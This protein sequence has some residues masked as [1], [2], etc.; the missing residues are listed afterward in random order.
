[1]QKIDRAHDNNPKEFWKK[2]VNSVPSKTLSDMIPKDQWRKYFSS[3]L[4]KKEDLPC[5][6]VMSPNYRR[7][8]TRARSWLLVHPA[9]Y[10]TNVHI[11]FKENSMEIVKTYTYLYA[12]APPMTSQGII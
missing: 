8:W 11:D 6:N 7:T 1:L 12:H 10:Q 2:E 5:Q 9:G 3:L 4:Q